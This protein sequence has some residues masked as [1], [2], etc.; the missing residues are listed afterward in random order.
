MLIPERL[1]LTEKQLL[2]KIAKNS[3][4]CKKSLNAI[5]IFCVG[6]SITAIIIISAL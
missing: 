5:L 1:E 6:I 4:S 2:E 3:E